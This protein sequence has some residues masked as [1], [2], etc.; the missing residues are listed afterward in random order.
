M[1]FQV[2]DFDILHKVA[3]EYF[4]CFCPDNKKTFTHLVGS[5]KYFHY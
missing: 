3:E 1:S 4:Q 2:K 5:L